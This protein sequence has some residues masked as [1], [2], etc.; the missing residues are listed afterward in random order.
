VRVYLDLGALKRPFDDHTQAR[1]RLEADAVLELLAAPAER[2]TFVHSGA[3]DV[4]NSQNPMPWRA[5][6]VSAWLQS[7]GPVPDPAT[8][9]VLRRV[10]ELMAL[11]VRNFDALHIAFAELAGA[12]V[13]ATTDDRLLGLGDRHAASL[14]VRFVDVVSLAREVLS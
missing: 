2:V 11:G 9:E 14:A 5:A 13:Y 8:D 3:H 6:R 10:R 12:D 1:I 7:V 4:E